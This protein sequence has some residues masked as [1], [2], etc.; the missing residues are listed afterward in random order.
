MKLR[1]VD[2]ALFL[3]YS[4]LS[5]EAFLLLAVHTLQ[6]VVRHHDDIVFLEISN[7]QSLALRVGAVEDKRLQGSIGI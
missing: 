5:G 2:D 3:V 4:I 6:R 1:G 7:L